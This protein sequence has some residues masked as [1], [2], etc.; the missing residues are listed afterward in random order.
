MKDPKFCKDCK[1]SSVDEHSS[2][3]LR[4]VN[5]KVNANDEYALSSGVAFR[6]SSTTEERKGGWFSI[7]GKKGKQYA[8]K[9]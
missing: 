9:L 1:W 6:G 3:A 8:P 2:W 4:C 7:C 5:P